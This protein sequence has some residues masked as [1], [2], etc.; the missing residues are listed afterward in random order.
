MCSFACVCAPRA[1]AHTTTTT[2]QGC[3]RA[4]HVC[5]CGWARG[6]LRASTMRATGDTQPL[7]LGSI[8]HGSQPTERRLRR[9]TPTHRVRRHP[10]DTC[11]CP[12]RDNPSWCG[13]RPH[14]ARHAPYF[15]PNVTA[16]KETP[17][18][19]RLSVAC[20]S[21]FPFHFQSQLLVEVPYASAALLDLLATRRLL[22]PRLVH[23]PSP[24]DLLAS[25]CIVPSARRSVD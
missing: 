16:S 19:F 11:P 8:R 20:L 5:A 14:A 21:S 25:F 13:G 1:R 12:R 2:P 24:R 4:P 23:R 6:V 3:G 7:G 17:S 18:S 10:T 22:F 15:L 9:A